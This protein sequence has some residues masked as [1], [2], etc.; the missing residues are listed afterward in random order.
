MAD[1]LQSKVSTNVL[2]V[3]I[4]GDFAQAMHETGE[5]DIIVSYGTSATDRLALVARVADMTMEFARVVSRNAVISP[6][7]TIDVGVVVNVNV[8]I[9]P[10]A[11]VIAQVMS[12]AVQASPMTRASVGQ[13]W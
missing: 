13:R 10:R 4:V 3:P 2:D 12:T 6:S 1:D 5:C 11:V 8:T 9:S 7:A